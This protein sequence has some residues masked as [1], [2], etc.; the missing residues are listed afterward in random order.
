MMRRSH[1]DESDAFQW[2]ES[3]DEYTRISLKNAQSRTDSRGSDRR[4]R[5]LM[6][7]F[8]S[9]S[10]A[11]APDTASLLACWCKS[12]LFGSDRRVDRGCGTFAGR[13]STCCLR[14]G[15]ESVCSFLALSMKRRS[16]Q[17]EG[18]RED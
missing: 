11:T 10:E 8:R 13:C 5:R 14:H 7:R 3:P 17:T 2:P 4:S 16:L 1:D 12:G 6:I 18:K 15:H 9:L